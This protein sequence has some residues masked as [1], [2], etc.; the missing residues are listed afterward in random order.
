MC[1]S[2]LNSQATRCNPAQVRI[3]QPSKGFDAGLYQSTG[4]HVNKSSYVCCCLQGPT[5][6][7][8]NAGGGIS[9]IDLWEVAVVTIPEEQTVGVQTNATRPD[10]NT[11]HAI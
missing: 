7:P 1:R 10:K 5:L 11:T 6:R 9:P 3:Y 8:R 4:F 2:A